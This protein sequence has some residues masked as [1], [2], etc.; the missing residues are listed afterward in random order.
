M[1]KRVTYVGFLLALWLVFAASLGAASSEPRRGGTLRLG[2]QRDLVNMNP[3]MATT[4]TEVNIR[5]LMFETL[6]A[7][8]DD[9]KLLPVLAESWQASPD[10]KVYIFKLRKGVKFHNGDEMTAEDVKYSIDYTVNPDNGAYGLQYL[11]MVARAEVVDKHTLVV[12]LRKQSPAFL[13]SLTSIRSFSV[14]PKGSLPEGSKKVSA[15]PPGTGPFKFV[16][17]KPRERIVF[18]RNDAYWGHKAYLDRVVL[19][20]IPN[21]TVRFT[22]L[23]SGDLDIVEHVPYEWV[24]QIQAGKV[25][26]LGL[27][28]APG[29][30]WRRLLFNMI[31]PPFNNKKL[32]QAVAHAM[33]KKEIIEAA[34]FGLAEPTDQKYP[35]KHP[36]YVKGVPSFGHDLDKGR[37]LLEES[38]FM[39]KTVKILTE[40]SQM[41]EAEAQTLQAQ[42]KRIG[43]N[44]EIETVDRGAFLN[45]QRTGEFQF[46]TEGG[47]AYPDPATTYTHVHKCLK[48]PKKRISNRSGYCDKEV[49][50]LLE[51]L[52]TEINTAKRR[53]ILARFLARVNDDLPEIAIAALARHFAYRD[54]VK[55]FTTNDNA[56]FYF[57]GGGLAYTWLD[58]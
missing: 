46:L 19:R 31:D 26:G 10:G 32:R 4:S 43:L 47:S 17:W 44:V 6:V 45:R 42:L 48:D 35:V 9:D 33:N 25:R 2:T 11:N 29:S 57:P 39:G 14:V 1:A 56:D 28:E 5:G 7:L 53:E 13:P 38:G 12:H 30:N 21:E 3:M 34:Y 50:G 8:D 15:Y 22:A 23:R 37:K 27:A 55:G 40:Q 58:K 54:N 41:R 24:K 52:D 51:S 36:W 18:D 16:E 49:D 20:P